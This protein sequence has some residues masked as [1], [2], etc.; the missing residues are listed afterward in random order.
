MSQSYIMGLYKGENCKN[1]FLRTYSTIQP[2]MDGF[3][4]LC[5]H[6]LTQLT[7]YLPW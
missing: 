4:L 1:Q 6:I 7:E 2:M 3:L 5:Q